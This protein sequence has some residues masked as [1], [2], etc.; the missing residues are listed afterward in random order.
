MYSSLIWSLFALESLFWMEGDWLKGVGP[1]SLRFLHYLVTIDTSHMKRGM[2]FSQIYSFF[3]LHRW[4]FSFYTK[5]VSAENA[6]ILFWD[7]TQTP[8]VM[9][10]DNLFPNPTLWIQQCTQHINAI[11]PRRLRQINICQSWSRHKKLKIFIG[12]SASQTVVVTRIWV[13]VRQ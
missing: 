5:S 4:T 3:F 11:R 2:S 6:P 8:S 10:I 7:E 1:S 12:Y 13:A 9:W